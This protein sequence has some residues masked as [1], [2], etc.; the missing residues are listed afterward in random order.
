VI[1]DNLLDEGVLICRRPSARLREK[2]FRPLIIAAIHGILTRQT[3][4]NWPEHFRAYMLTRDPAVQVVTKSYVAGPFPAWNVWAKNWYLAYSLAAEL[5]VLVRE[6]N[7]R[8]AFFAHS[9]G[10]DVALKTIRLLAQ[11]RIDTEAVV[12]TGAAIDSDI[13]KNG[14]QQLVRNGRL[15]RAFSYSSPGD[16]IVR[17]WFI[18]PYGHLGRDGFTLKGKPAIGCDAIVTRWFPDCGHSDYFAN[19]AIPAPRWRSSRIFRDRTFDQAY[20]DLTG[21][22]IKEQE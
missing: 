15:E 2:I 8:L 7:A 4:P 18:W 11:R 22:E 12:L 3:V 9:N 10:C 17:H 5:Q 20:Q 16:E 6:A 14:I 13:R 1:E 21:K 19:K